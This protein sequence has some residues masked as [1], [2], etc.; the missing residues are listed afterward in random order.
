MVINAVRFLLRVAFL[1]LGWRVTRTGESGPA[2]YGSFIAQCQGSFPSALLQRMFPLPWPWMVPVI[3]GRLQERA[4][5]PHS[6]F[7]SSHGALEHPCLGCVQGC[8]CGVLTGSCGQAQLLQPLWVSW[9]GQME[10][11]NVSQRRRWILWKMR[12]CGA[13]LPCEI[14]TQEGRQDCAGSPVPL[15]CGFA[16]RRREKR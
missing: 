4:P 16:G 6:H 1:V 2:G 12:V 7:L 15:L 13:V 3:P 8:S 11:V 10:R 9:P 5:V 14:F